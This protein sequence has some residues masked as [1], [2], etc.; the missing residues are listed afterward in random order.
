MSFIDLGTDLDNVKEPETV[1]EG[2]YD[3]IVEGVTEKEENGELKGISIRHGI[4]GHPDAAT[5]FHYL[6]MPMDGDDEDKVNFK[7]RFIKNYFA[8]FGIPCKKGKFDVADFAGCA[9]KVKLVLDTY[10]D[11]VNNKIKL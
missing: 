11:Q 4:E 2:M 6:S 9:G 5:V 1:P 3:L 8:A 10:N 7:L